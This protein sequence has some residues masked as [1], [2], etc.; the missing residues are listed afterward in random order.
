MLGL[1]KG[2]LFPP[3]HQLA[4]S[5]SDNF[6]GNF[7]EHVSYANWLAKMKGLMTNVLGKTIGSDCCVGTHTLRKTGYL[8]AIWGCLKTMPPSQRLNTFP[9]FLL[10][11][12]LTAA[13]HKSVQNATTYAQDS[14]SLLCLVQD[15]RNP[16]SHLVFKWDSIHITNVGSAAAVTLASRPYQKTLS[17]VASWYFANVLKIVKDETLTI[18]RAMEFAIDFKPELEA[19][20]AAAKYTNQNCSPEV[21]ATIIALYG[22][23]IQASAVALSSMI[24]PAPQVAPPPVITTATDQSKRK[25]GEGKVSLLEGYTKVKRLRTTPEKV[26]K[27]VAFY[28]QA[29]L[30]PSQFN[31]NE[32]TW[33]RKI[34]SI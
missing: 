15:E 23:A 26:E 22:K 17:D 14:A 25:R 34:V 28:K 6:S 3:R 10:S 32:R 24:V 11:F 19:K 1:K 21:A 16:E 9:A 4:S 8:F 2:F 29:N 13:R 12:I 5:S 20:E 7:S 31:E 27:L 33:W 18:T 30:Q